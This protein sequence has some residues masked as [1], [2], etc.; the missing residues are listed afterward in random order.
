MYK[1]KILMFDIETSPNEADVW[2]F[3]NT[4]V[5]MDQIR[6]DGWIMSFAGKWLGNPEI[7]YVDNQRG[8]KGEEALVKKLWAML[9]EADIVVGHNGKKFDCG[10]FNGR[11]AIYRL[12]PPSPYKVV[13]TLLQARKNFYFPSYKLE[14]LCRVFNVARK[15]SHAKYSGHKLW[16]ACREGIKEAWDE[17]REYNIQDIVCLEELYLVM[18]PWMQQHPNLAVLI[19][20]TKEVCTGCGSPDHIHKRGFS[21]TN[22]SKFQRY[23]CVPASGGCGKWMRG[24]VNLLTKEIR[25]ALLV[26]VM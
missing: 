4:N 8:P 23:Q 25:E 26:S 17:M 16:V 20:D 22:M 5:G 13:D 9:D 10:W 2:S 14:Y 12:P 15:L 18:L 6:K 21:V 3:F 1:P 19:E 7:T 24:R 11:A